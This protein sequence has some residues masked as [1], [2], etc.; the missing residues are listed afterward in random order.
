MPI[1]L[2]PHFRYL[3]IAYMQEPNCLLMVDMQTV[4]Q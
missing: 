4:A 2:T 3:L 1:Q